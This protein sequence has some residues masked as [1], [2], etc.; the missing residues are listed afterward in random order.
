MI[1]NYDDVNFIN[2]KDYKIDHNKNVKLL[3]LLEKVYI[4]SLQ[5]DLFFTVKGGMGFLLIFNKLYRTVEDLDF[6]IIRSDLSRWEQYLKSIGF[7]LNVQMG[8]LYRYYNS[9]E[10]AFIDL[11][12]DSKVTAFMKTKEIYNGKLYYDISLKFFDEKYFYNRK[13]DYDDLDFY[14]NYINN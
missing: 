7:F 13:K 10:D 12:L 3:C 2:F 4:D 9:N 11:I 6:A 14:K 1:I 8:L 5:K